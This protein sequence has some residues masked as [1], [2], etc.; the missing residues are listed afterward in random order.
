MK[1]NKI[2]AEAIITNSA[3]LQ[4]VKN[5]SNRAQTFRR[6]HQGDRMSFV[7]NRPKCSPI[8]FSPKLTH[9]YAIFTVD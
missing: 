9:N 8:H 3:K 2:D 7:K 5:K 4:M 1:F 6:G